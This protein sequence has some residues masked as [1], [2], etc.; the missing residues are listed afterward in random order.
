MAMIFISN[1]RSALK[2][3]GPSVAGS[4][5]P[6]D[7]SVC[8]WK[9][10]AK[11][12]NYSHPENLFALCVLF[13]LLIMKSSLT[14][15]FLSCAL[16]ALVSCRSN[17]TGTT[18]YQPQSYPPPAPL[19]SPFRPSSPPP[20]IRATCYI[21][22]DASTGK[23][24]ASRNP[25]TRR[26]VASTQKLVTALVVSKSGNLDRKIQVQ[27]S[28][29]RVEP[30]KLGLRTGEIISRRQL[31][32]AF[33]IKSGNDGGNALARDNA[34]SNAAFAARMNSIARYCG[35]T[36]S[37]FCTPHGLNHPNQYSTARDISRIAMVAYRDPVIRDAVRRQSIPFHGYSL[38]NTN[39]LLKRM[40]EC[41]GMKTG[42]THAAG[43][44]LVSSASRFG[45]SVILV[46]LGSRS[47]YIWDDGKAMMDWGLRNL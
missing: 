23:V 20:S 6:Q 34:G 32:Y 1:E 11:S 14:R 36:S 39:D 29:T 45:K 37:N 33:L 19:P 9:A 47:A 25:D 27:A 42:Y 46:Q 5:I 2:S 44:C 43:K 17:P 40:P 38:K 28:D 24:L 18:T 7:S 31:L 21:L 30:T 10:W 13:L 3:A 15:I 35:A 41:N 4:D 22:I 12:R 16:A 26:P 8:Q